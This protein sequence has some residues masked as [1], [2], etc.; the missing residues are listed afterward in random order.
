MT[1]RFG[2]GPKALALGVLLAGVAE[3]ALRSYGFANPPL[4]VEDERYE[5]AF[6]PD[7]SLTRFGNR[8]LTDE[9]G[10]RNG[11]VQEGECVAVTF[12]GDSVINGGAP[13]D[14]GALA[15]TLLDSLAGPRARVL[16]V[17]A[18][19]WGPDNA[20]AFLRAHG[21][22]DP[23]RI[24][25]VFSSHD[26]RDEMTF[27]PYVGEDPG[28]PGARPVSA[29]GEAFARYVV[30]P[31]LRVVL[32][33]STRLG[34]VGGSPSSGP[35]EDADRLNPGW[36]ALVEHARRHD[37]DLMVYLHAEASEAAA[38]AFDDEGQELL[39]ALDSLGVPVLSDLD[40]IRPSEYRDYIH[41]NAEGQARMAERLAPYVSPCDE[42]RR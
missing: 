7:Q 40:R 31:I 5:Y 34:I 14:Q 3:L 25:A 20:A 6:A 21:D 18:G 11:P 12:V 30:P 16:N 4:L 22:G 19:S 2:C 33:V 17:S 41:I 1:S 8:F 38:G 10:R 23:R 9:L 35:P 13:T 29:L 32:R 27:A 37:V 42:G 24:I 28:A 36:L 15:T 26:A 39:A